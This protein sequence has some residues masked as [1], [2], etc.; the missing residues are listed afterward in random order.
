METTPSPL[1]KGEGIDRGRWEGFETG[2]NCRRGAGRGGGA[3]R[4]VVVATPI[5]MLGPLIVGTW[6][7]KKLY[8]IVYSW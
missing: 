6:Y 5:E 3:G 1:V 8:L 4:V 7:A 2:N